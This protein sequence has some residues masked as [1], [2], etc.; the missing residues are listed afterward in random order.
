MSIRRRSVLYLGLASLLN[1]SV[2]VLA[3]DFLGLFA[4]TLP[5]VLSICVIS[6]SITALFVSVWVLTT[7]VTMTWLR[8]I[9]L[10]VVFAASLATVL[11]E[12]MVLISEDGSIG[13]GL[14]PATGTLLHVLL[15][16][17]LFTL[18][19]IHN[20][21]KNIAGMTRDQSISTRD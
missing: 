2:S 17:L 3:W 5:P 11:G 9:A 13:V 16:A 20:A 19:F 18:C 10:M 6:L 14:I 8:R 4:N 7:V 21:A 1:F 15:A 12:V